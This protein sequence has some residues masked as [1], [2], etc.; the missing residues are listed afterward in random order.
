MKTE[1][2]SISPSLQSLCP[3]SLSLQT[4][5]PLQFHHCPNHSFSVILRFGDA[6]A[7]LWSCT[8]ENVHKNP[9]LHS[10]RSFFPSYT[11][12]SITVFGQWHRGS[13]RDL[14]V[15]A[16]C[17]KTIQTSQPLRR[18]LWLNIVLCCSSKLQEPWLRLRRY[19]VAGLILNFMILGPV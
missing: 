1:M 10:E 15:A 2:R 16:N 12:L 18:T 4:L 7:D 17:G 11:S 14:W 8:A 5:S 19:G 9:F 6:P 3:P 13:G